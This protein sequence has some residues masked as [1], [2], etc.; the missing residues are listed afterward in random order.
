VIGVRGGCLILSIERSIDR[1][2][3]PG[4][5][6]GE[7]RMLSFSERISALVPH[8]LS[9]RPARDLLLSSLLPRQLLLSFL[10]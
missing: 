3:E 6:I 7:I 4:V 8:G 10:E 5:S 2:P 1:R 9:L